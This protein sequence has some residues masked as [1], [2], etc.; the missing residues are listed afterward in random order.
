MLSLSL[1]FLF[2]EGRE[3]GGNDLRGGLMGGGGGVLE[4]RGKDEDVHDQTQ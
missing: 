3:R 4:D 1:F 2:G